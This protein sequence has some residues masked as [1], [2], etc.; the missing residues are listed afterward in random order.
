M[1]VYRSV[2]FFLLIFFYAISIEHA[3][4]TTPTLCH[5]QSFLGTNEIVHIYDKST[6]DRLLHTSFAQAIPIRYGTEI[7]PIRITAVFL[8]HLF[9][10]EIRTHIDTWG[11]KKSR[12]AGFHHDFEKRLEQS[13]I[14]RFTNKK[15]DPLTGVVTGTVEEQHGIS[16]PNIF[17]PSSW[18]PEQ[19]LNTI[20]TSMH[21]AKKTYWKRECLVIEGEAAGLTIKSVITKTGRLVTAYPIEDT[22]QQVTA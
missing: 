1:K 6:I 2:L 17:F 10:V 13:G 22:Y 12:L 3:A 4:Y 7:I 9:G 21:N 20:L 18:T 11:N 19:T 15:T 5:E 8:K 14:I 16:K